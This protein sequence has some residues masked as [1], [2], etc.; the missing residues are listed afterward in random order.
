MNNNPIKMVE[1][2]KKAEKF[3]QNWNGWHV[4]TCAK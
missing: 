1:L 2:L 3:S 4:C